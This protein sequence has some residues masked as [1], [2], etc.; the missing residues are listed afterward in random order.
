MGEVEGGAAEA[1][2]GVAHGA[3]VVGGGGEAPEDVGL[4]VEVW[5]RAGRSPLHGHEGVGQADQGP[6][7]VTREG[8]AEGLGAADARHEGAAAGDGG[9][10]EVLPGV[11]DYADYGLAVDG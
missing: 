2:E 10:E 4:E 3:A 8:Q 11:V 6:R 9:E 1:A 5:T 7:G